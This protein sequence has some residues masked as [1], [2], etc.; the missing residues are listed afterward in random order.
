MSRFL[1]EN[2]AKLVPYVPGEQVNEK[3]I[4]LNTNESPYPPSPEVIDAVNKNEI[5][6][7]NL[8]PDPTCKVL[9]E[10][11]AE[12]V[13]EIIADKAPGAIAA[14]VEVPVMMFY[15]RIRAELGIRRILILCG[16]AWFLK[17]LLTA[18]AVAP[19]MV[20]AAQLA[21]KLEMLIENPEERVRMGKNARRCA[22]ERFD[23]K[24]SYQ[25]LI[26]VILKGE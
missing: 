12:K 2:Y 11:L 5:S 18:F 10:K 16:W 20:Y 23:R 22:E 14:I 24:N 13:D 8:Y 17:N 1:S 4:K 21:E 19:A 9:K 6:M 25:E 3:V 26:D 7:L 15:S